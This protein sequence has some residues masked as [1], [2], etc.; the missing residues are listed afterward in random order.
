MFR[1][2]QT[3]YFARTTFAPFWTSSAAASNLRYASILRRAGHLC[4]VNILRRGGHLCCVSI[5][6]R[7]QVIS[8]V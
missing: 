1:P 6:R 7:S 3:R 8:V 4:C 2:C 5:I